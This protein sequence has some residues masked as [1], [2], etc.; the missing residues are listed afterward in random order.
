MAMA[1]APAAGVAMAE[2]AAAAD[3]AANARRDKGSAEFP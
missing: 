1:E 2:A 3:K